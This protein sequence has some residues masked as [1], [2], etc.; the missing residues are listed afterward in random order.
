MAKQKAKPKKPLNDQIKKDTQSISDWKTILDQSPNH[1]VLLD[2]ELRILYTNRPSPGLTLQD[3]VGVPLYT[4]VEEGRQEEIRRKLAGTLKT[5]RPCS[6]QTQ[7]KTPNGDII[8]YQSEVVPWKVKNRKVGLILTARDITDQKKTQDQ[9]IRKTEFLDATI[10]NSPFPTWVADPDG[11]I[12]RTNHALRKTLGFKDA[13]LIGK[14]NILQD[15]NILKQGFLPQVKTVFTEHKMAR[16][17]MPWSS[18]EIRHVEYTSVRDMWIE[19]TIFPIL[20]DHKNLLSVVCQWVDISKQKNYAASLRE[21]ELKY[22]SFFPQF[23]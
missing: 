22:L 9:L 18:A 1:M 8:Y 6:Y 20:D 16:F 7:F 4:L 2:K 14:Y 3:L 5:S 21:S 11:F 17:T 12:V 13:Q 23:F 10:D 19:V 15:E